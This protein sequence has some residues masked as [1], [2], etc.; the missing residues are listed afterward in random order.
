MP[1]RMPLNRGQ[2]QKGSKRTTLRFNDMKNPNQAVDELNH[3]LRL[4]HA[5]SQKGDSSYAGEYL[6]LSNLASRLGIFRGYLVDIAASDG[7]SQSCTL[8]FLRDQ[9]WSGLAVEMDPLKF[10]SLSYLYSN[11]SNCCLAKSRVT[12]SNIGSL[13][14]A[15]EVPHDFDLLNLDIDSYDLY[16]I[17]SMLRSSFQPKII[18]MEINEKIPPGIFFTVDFK[19]SHYWQGDHFYGCSLDAAA[20]TVKRYGYILQSLEYNNAIFIREDCARSPFLRTDFQDLT[21]ES[22]YA[23]GY[24]NRQDRYRLFHWNQDVNHWLDLPPQEACVEIAKFFT[25]YNGTYKLWALKQSAE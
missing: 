22:A 23:A 14:N 18:S 7:Y 12:P 8:G 17:D 3:I 2:V 15:F 9:G 24:R 16:V 13:L 10:A 4:H 25:K 21:P 5:A 20:I 11:F 19:E 1:L 6:A